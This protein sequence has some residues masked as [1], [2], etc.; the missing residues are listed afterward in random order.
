MLKF[1]KIFVENRACFM[2]YLMLQR[3]KVGV[4]ST[5]KHDLAQLESILEKKNLSHN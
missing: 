2:V 1:T 4:L 3:L 5:Q